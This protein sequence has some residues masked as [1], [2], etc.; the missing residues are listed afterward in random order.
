MDHSGNIDRVEGRVPNEGFFQVDPNVRIAN[1]ETNQLPQMPE[2]VPSN[3][4]VPI[5]SNEQLTNPEIQAGPKLSTPQP[6]KQVQQLPDQS[7]QASS[8]G[9][10]SAVMTTTP[11]SAADED[12][13][14]KEWVSQAKKVIS[15]TK[16]NPHEQ[17]K[18]VAELMRDYVKKRYGKEV[19]KAPDDI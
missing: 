11:V 1:P 5:A 3:P 19:G 18:L 4:E 7:V 6:T 14:E 12:L 9:S 8:D 10:T 13:I 2:I 15:T 17:A 16:D